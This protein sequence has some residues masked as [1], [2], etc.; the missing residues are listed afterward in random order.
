MDVPLFDSFVLLIIGI[1]AAVG[2]YF[3]FGYLK[4]RAEET[5]T[6]LDDLIVHSLG[7][8][9]IILA[10]F[11]PLYFAI[12]HAIVVYP[13]FQWITDSKLLLAGYILVATWII[14]SFIDGFLRTYGLALAE[15]TETDL[16][17]RIIE[18][19]Q[20][21]AKYLI[22]FVGIL[23]VLTI[24]NINITPLIAGAGIFGIA[25]A[26]AA[27]D[28]FSNFFGGAVIITD[29]PFKIGDRVLIN[30]ILGD[31]T[32]IGPR[33]TRIIT[34]DSDVVTIPNNKI[35][36][37]VVR[38]FSLP[39]PQVRIQIPVTVAYGTDIGHVKKV[40]AGIANEAMT[41]R[42]DI[43]A[44]DP[45]PTVYLIRMDKTAM[46]FEMTVYANEFRHNTVIKD[47]LNTR[48]IEE[49]RKEGIIIA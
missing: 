9:L 7:A 21:I 19:L 40:L 4:R 36:T 44:K 30:D 13:E 47:L 48:I 46:I 24:F 38:N 32:H 18:I 15:R 31:V 28:L 45:D 35:T 10:F 2:V 14:A 17:D 43:I 33:S 12:L 41:G 29:Q 25:I 26:L 22:W 11:I 6:K 49:F 20:Q 3:I 37:N 8:P 1:I 5:E 23:Y 42:A 39:S 27:Q 16:D 34:L